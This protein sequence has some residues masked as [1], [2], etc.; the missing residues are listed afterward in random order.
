M[1]CV[2]ELQTANLVLRAPGPEAAPALLAYYRDNAAH[3]APWEPPRPADFLTEAHWARRLAAQ[4]ED[5]EAGR[6]LALTLARHDA[7]ERVVGV[8]NFTGVQ[9]G[10][11]LACNLG[12]SLAAAAEG[13]G[14]MFEALSV[15]IPFAFERLELHRVQANYRPVNE[16]SGRLLRRLGFVVEGYA[17]DY[18]W[19]DG[20]WRDHVLTSRSRDGVMPALARVERASSA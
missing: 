19:I 20:A 5:L 1:A 14:L 10:P 3:L 18:L 8:A 7:P 4:L 17:R 11:L 2:V 12:Y 16:R 9:R 6:G 13:R 15:A